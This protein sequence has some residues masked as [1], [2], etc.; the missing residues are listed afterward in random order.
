MGGFKNETINSAFDIGIIN[1]II[2]HLTK[3]SKQMKVDCIATDNLLK[4]NEDA[5][6]NRLIAVY[7]NTEPGIFRYEPQSPEHYDRE[8]DHYIGRTDIKVISGDYFRDEKAY[9]IIECKR[10]DGSITLNQ[11]YITK[12]VERFFSPNPHPKYSSYYLQNIMFGYVVRAIDITENADKIDKLQGSLLKGATASQFTLMQN[13]NSQYYV[14]A[15]VYVAPDIGQIEL[16]H[17]FFD[18]ADVICE[19]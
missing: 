13:E 11:N 5:I 10:I 15:C 1:V 14:Y 3:C 9:Y 19:K 2:A 7:L 4:N 16:N 12:G 18:F 17:L 6:T 8:T